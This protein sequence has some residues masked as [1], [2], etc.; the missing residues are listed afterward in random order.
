M[1]SYV[2]IKLCWFGVRR[3]SYAH[4][5]TP[6][7]YTYIYIYGIVIVPVHAFALM[8]VFKLTW[9]DIYLIIAQGKRYV[10]GIIFKH[11]CQRKIHFIITIYFFNNLVQWYN[12]FLR[13]SKNRFIN[14]SAV[15]NQAGWGLL[16]QAHF[17]FCKCMC[18]VIWISRTQSWILNLSF[19][20]IFGRHRR[21]HAAQIP[22]KYKCYI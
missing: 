16:Q 6:F 19:T 22:V 15:S 18:Y 14:I 13:Q 2:I 20:F 10:P 12:I 3:K 5:Y 11:K 8:N 21:S 1:A 17:R 9:C 4:K 7:I